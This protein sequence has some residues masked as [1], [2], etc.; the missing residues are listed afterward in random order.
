VTP[1]DAKGEV[2]W[3]AY[4]ALVRQ[5]IAAGVAG[6]I[7]CGTTGESSTL[8]AEERIRLISEAVKLCRGTTGSNDTSKTVAA[9]AEAQAAGVDGVMVITPYYNRPS[10]AGLIAH[11]TAVAAVGVPIMLYNSGRSGVNLEP[12][13]VAE[14]RKLPAMAAIKEASGSVEQAS[15]VAAA[16]DI[17]ILS[18]DD[19]LT[20]PMM[21]VGAV[22]VAS[23]VSNLLPAEV[24]AL[25][26]AAAAGDY[27]AARAAHY[28]LLPFFTTMFVET[29]PVPIKRA[30]ELA[31]LIPSAAVRLPLVGLAAESDA[32]V[33]ALLRERGML[34]G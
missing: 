11:F 5:Q 21:S 32:A 22:G 33:V 23:V 9:T 31:G 28:K 13:T 16:C 27:A 30:M 25:V 12:S 29:N 18:G 15:A 26:D 24:V 7:P 2:D 10:Q 8:T 17:P 4:E 6:V 19:G 34:K 3:V 20:V 1:F 14:L